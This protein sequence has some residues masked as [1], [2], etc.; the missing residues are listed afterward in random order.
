MKIEDARGVAEVNAASWRAAYQD[1]LPR[2][3]LSS[4]DVNT[5]AGTWRQRIRRGEVRKWVVDVEGTVWAY[6]TA[7]PC[8]DPDM[9]PGFCG[10][11]YELYVHPQAWKMGMGHALMSRAWRA[12][13]REGVLWGVLWVLEANGEARAFYER[14]G[15]QHDGQRRLSRTGGCLLPT[16]R[17]ARPLNAVAPFSSSHAS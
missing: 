7:G 11:I 15:L 5:M 6:A 16:L 13:E 4:L 9:E 12:L 8:R 2:S 3:F 10:E 1:L 14:N 17:Y